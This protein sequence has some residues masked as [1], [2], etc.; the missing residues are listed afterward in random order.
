MAKKW[1]VSSDLCQICQMAS[2]GLA[3]ALPFFFF[4]SL[5]YATS[6]SLTLTYMAV[7]EMKD[8]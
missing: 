1:T 4:L 7:G 5:M 2:L 6:D 8:K 3:F